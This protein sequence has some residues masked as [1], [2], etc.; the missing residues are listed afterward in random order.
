MSRHDP[1]Y[2]NSVW[3]HF[4][5]WRRGLYDPS[6]GRLEL[7]APDDKTPAHQ[8]RADT[9]R[10]FLRDNRDRQ[11]LYTLGITKRIGHFNRV[12]H[13]AA[14]LLAVFLLV[15]LLVTISYMPAFGDLSA[16]EH[17]EVAQRYIEKGLAETG[18]VN[19]VAGMI[20]DYRAFDTF[21]ESCVLFAAM[22]C[23]L[24][25]LRV[26]KTDDPDSVTEEAL[27][28]WYFEPHENT[29]LQVVA[30]VLVPLIIIFG[31]YVV[32]NGH[33]SPGGGFSGGAIIGTGL[34]LY[35]TAFGFERVGPL[36][37]EKLIKTLTVSALGFYCL[38]KSYSFYTGAN[39]LHSIISPGVPGAILSGGLIVYLNICVGVVV[40]CTIYTFF[41]A[42]RKGGF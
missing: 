7:K 23:V 11:E 30:R 33:L 34:I 19:I 14:V 6:A 13:I 36:L 25:L 4:A 38:A 8:D 28:D 31:A 9:L 2:D 39:G 18:A 42:F 3:E 35:L 37:T 41:S 5:L 16:P 10:Q 1:K 32:L 40:S 22:C 24:L 26:D 20:L 29:I 12:Y 17:N 15:F 21:G 27:S